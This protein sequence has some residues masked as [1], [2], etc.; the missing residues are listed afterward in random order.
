MM[1]AGIGSAWAQY[2]DITEQVVQVTPEQ[3]MKIYA[4][5]NATGPLPV[6]LY[7]HCGGW[8]A[9]AVEL[10]DGLC[11]DIV[12]RSNIIL[13]SPHYRLAPEHPWP[14]GIDDVCAGY[15]WMHQNATKYGGDPRLKAIMGGSAG[16]NLTQCLGVKYADQGELRPVALLSGA[17]VFCDP[18]A[19][20]EHYKSQ[21]TPAKFADV[22]MFNQDQM[23]I[24]R[25]ESFLLPLYVGTCN[26]C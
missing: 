10:E 15:E 2:P 23:A 5:T 4:P 11:R 22:P 12:H 1:F 21:L 13:F 6:G 18:R 19:T 26:R 25:G 20:P 24:A 14:A 7:I 17:G 8:Y 16:G 3:H 9:G